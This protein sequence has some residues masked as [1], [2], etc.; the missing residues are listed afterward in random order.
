MKTLKKAIL[1]FIIAKLLIIYIII[2][3]ICLLPTKAKSQYSE[4]IYM[5][6]TKTIIKIND[7]EVCLKVVYRIQLMVLSKEPSFRFFHQNTVLSK[8]H[9]SSNLWFLYSSSFYNTSE[10][11][12]EAVKMYK[13]L[14]YKDCFIVKNYLYSL[15]E[16]RNDFPTNSV[17]DL[18]SSSTKVDSLSSNLNTSTVIIGDKDSIPVT[19]DNTSFNIKSNNKIEVSNQ[20]SKKTAI[21]D[22][23]VYIKEKDDE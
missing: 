23:P 8:L 12:K 16:E 21:I 3:I 19:Y 6:P 1:K 15:H 18:I 22:I 14:G 2:L 9:S 4:T 7:Q 20:K 13:G 11:A 17:T 5:P 10:E